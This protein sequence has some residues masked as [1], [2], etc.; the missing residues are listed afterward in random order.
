MDNIR[1]KSIKR[2]QKESQLYRE[3]SSLF[4]R[5]TL[6]DARLKNVFVNRIVLSPDKGM[7]SIFLYTDE[8]KEAFDEIKKTLVLY[9]PSLRKAVADSIQSRRVPDLLFKFDSQ[10]EKQQ[11]IETLL[12]KIKVEEPSN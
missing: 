10:F 1:A 2:A 11:R 4:L 9:K 5:L 12:E 3:I 7:C 8:G 6:D